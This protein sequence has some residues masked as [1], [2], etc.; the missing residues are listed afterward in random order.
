LETELGVKLFDRGASPLAL[1]PA[2][3]HFIAEA[4]ELLYKEQQLLRSMERYRS[5]EAGTLTVG[6]TPFRSSYLIA[7]V[8]TRV[9]QR[10]PGIQ[11]RLQEEGSE[12]VRKDAADGKFDLAIVNLPVDD[13]VLE[14][15]PL[16]A[17]RLVML[18][19][20]T[21]TDMLV[22]PSALSVCMKDCAALP[23]AVVSSTQ[24]MRRLFDKLCARADISP[25]I[26]VEAVNLNTLYTMAHAQVAAVILPYQF[27]SH[28]PC[29]GLRIF[30]IED[31]PYIRQP[32]VV[33][34]RHQVMT[35]AASYAIRLLTDPSTV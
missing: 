33:T 28:M 25:N 6:I 8:I 9:R 32:V 2:G 27:V 12:A 22:D 30:D 4:E 26:V 10:F 18:V 3:E 21:L 7:D 24:E 19:P 17:D 23:F 34:R 1:T 14:V 5:G 29:D 11:I 35:D 13:S 20:E 31:A 15:R 16:A